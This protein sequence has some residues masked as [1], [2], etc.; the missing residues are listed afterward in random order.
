MFFIMS[1]EKLMN[2]SRNDKLLILF[3]QSYQQLGSKN[4]PQ[5]TSISPLKDWEDFA[6]LLEIACSIK[7]LFNLKTKGLL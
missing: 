2:N 6:E 7:S 3:S 1:G 5:V 4:Q